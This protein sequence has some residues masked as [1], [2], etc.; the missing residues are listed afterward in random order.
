M[1]IVGRTT[2]MGISVREY[3]HKLRK[4]FCIDSLVRRLMKVNPP[5]APPRRGAAT[6]RFPAT[7]RLLFIFP[8]KIR[9]RRRTVTTGCVA[10]RRTRGDLFPRQ[11]AGG[12]RLPSSIKEGA[13]VVSP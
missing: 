6:R 4:R 7:R 2:L 5:P 3:L 11:R 9:S 10:R 8:Y 1:G 13:G 12:V